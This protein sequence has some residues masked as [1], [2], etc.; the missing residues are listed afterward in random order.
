MLKAIR[1][2]ITNYYL[3]DLKSIK[4]ITIKDR[5]IMIKKMLGKILSVTVVLAA[6]VLLSVI[7]KLRAITNLFFPL[8]LMSLFPYYIYGVMLKLHR[9]EKSGL[10]H[11]P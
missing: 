8:F 9:R 6:I 11:N 4:N 3:P 10:Q 5:E 1:T 7:F 2:Y